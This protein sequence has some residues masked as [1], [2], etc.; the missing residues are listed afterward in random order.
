MAVPDSNLQPRSHDE[1]TDARLVDRARGDVEAFAALYR[2][3]YPAIQ[4][5][6]RRRLGGSGFVDDVVAETFLKALE[7][8]PRYEERGLPF[9]AWLY[10]IATSRISRQAR[11]AFRRLEQLQAEPVSEPDPDGPDRERIRRALLGLPDR[12][13][14]VIALHHLEGLSIDEVAAIL[15]C[16]PGTVKSRLAR[17][18]E[19]LRRRLEASGDPR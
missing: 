9:S 17:G 11:Q 12:F 14:S 6:V 10:R 1:T 7:Y 15:E 3:H 5:Y 19:A 13:Q 8:L 16:A 2:R 18:R 4:R